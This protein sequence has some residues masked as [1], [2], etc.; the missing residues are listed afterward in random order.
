[1]AIEAKSVGKGTTP[2]WNDNVPKQDTIYVLSSGKLNETTIFMG[3]DVIDRAVYDIMA[4][5]EAEIAKVLKRFHKKLTEADVHNRGWIQK[6]R[7]Q[8]FQEGGKEKTNYFTHADRLQCEKN[9]LDF[10]KQ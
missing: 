3:R 9:A 10:A 4:E 5:Q 1:V 2:M 8:H 6:S 7:K